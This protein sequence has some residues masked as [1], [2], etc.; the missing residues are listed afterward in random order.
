MKALSRSEYVDPVV[1]VDVVWS[2][3][4]F[5]FAS[6]SVTVLT[7]AGAPLVYAGSI[8]VEWSESVDYSGEI[9]DE[10]TTIGDVVFPVDV[11]LWYRQGR[12]LV[13]ARAEVSLWVEGRTYEEREPLTVGTVTASEYG[14]DGD[15]VTLSIQ[16]PTLDDT[17]L[18][19]RPEARA[20]SDTW[21]TLATELDGEPYPEVLGAPGLGTSNAERTGGSPAI[22]VNTSGNG[23]WLVATRAVKASTVDLVDATAGTIESVSVSLERDLLGRVVS[24]VAG[25]GTTARTVGNDYWIDWNGTDGGASFSGASTS[26]GGQLCMWL[27]RESSVTFDEGAWRALAPVLDGYRFGF[28]LDEPRSPLDVLRQ[29]IVPLLPIGLGRTP[30]G[31]A[32]VPI[33]LDAT[34][35]D[36]VAHLEVGRNIQLAGPVRVDSDSAVNDVTI[37]FAPRSDGDFDKRRRVMGEA[38][39]SGDSWPHPLARVSRALYGQRSQ[40]IETAFVYDQA[41]ADR[42]I[43]DMVQASALPPER[44][45]VTALLALS[46]L[47]AGSVV[48]LT[49]PTLH[50]AAQVAHVDSVQRSG[51]G[52][53]LELSVRQSLARD[54]PPF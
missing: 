16:P 9:P 7:S 48:T 6:R 12:P 8:E 3:R 11:A 20:T 25:G 1:L 50:Y 32:P 54:V 30:L 23:K 40:R 33:R 45:T 5:R 10:D 22:L 4:T 21:S 44:V 43:S 34:A 14:E 24:T 15:P 39:A 17:A 27:L 51:A 18:I 46:W 31:L 35:A 13:G 37:D 41:T 42:I 36:A 53:R 49:A 47:R 52:L 26:G 2:G 29:D 19:P 38:T 28:Y